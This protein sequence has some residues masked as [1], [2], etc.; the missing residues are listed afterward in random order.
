MYITV[1]MPICI[2]KMIYF[3]IL[4][5]IRYSSKYMQSIPADGMTR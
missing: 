1:C 4:V 5:R 3:Y 2:S